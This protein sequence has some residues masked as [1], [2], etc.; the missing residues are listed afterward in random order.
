MAN[1]HDTAAYDQA[2]ALIR[3]KI[4]S[5]KATRDTLARCQAE[6]EKLC[7]LARFYGDRVN[8]RNRMCQMDAGEKARTTLQE[9]CGENIR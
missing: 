1:D 7:K 2:M 5:L 8:W 6:N 9:V 3:D 4:A